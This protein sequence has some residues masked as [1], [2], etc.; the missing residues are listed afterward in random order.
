MMMK[1]MCKFH[2]KLIN[3]VRDHCYILRKLI[4]TRTS[5][6]EGRFKIECV[7]VVKWMNKDTLNGDSLTIIDMS[8]KCKIIKE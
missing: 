3:D 6:K 1:L 2:C 4:Y 5:F 7:F 8:L